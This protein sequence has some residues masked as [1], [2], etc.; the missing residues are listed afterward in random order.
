MW[1]HDAK[2]LRESIKLQYQCLNV[3]AGTAKTATC[4]H[5]M[6]CLYSTDQ[7]EIIKQVLEASGGANAPDLSTGLLQTQD[8]LTC[9]DPYKIDPE[10]WD[11]ACHQRMKDACLDSTDSCHDS[12]LATCYKCKLCENPSVC[13]SWKTANGCTTAQTATCATGEESLLQSKLNSTTAQADDVLALLA[14]NSQSTVQA[15]AT[16]GWDCG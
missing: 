7:L 9:R 8:P 15:K 2:D 12:S 4:T 10:S 6:Q 14:A 3:N 5:W 1:G 13:C 16:V 11:C